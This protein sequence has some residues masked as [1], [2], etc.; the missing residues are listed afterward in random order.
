MLYD[1]NS[2]LFAPCNN[3]YNLPPFSLS[4]SPS[5]NCPWLAVGFQ[6]GSRMFSPRGNKLV[7]IYDWE[8]KELKQIFDA[9]TWTTFT[10]GIASLLYCCAALATV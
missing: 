6:P 7:Y 1:V 5:P 10:V 3:Y 9:G 4:V 2:V 8:R